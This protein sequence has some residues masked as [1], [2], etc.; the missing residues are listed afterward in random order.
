MKLIFKFAI[1][2]I[3]VSSVSVFNIGNRDNERLSPLTF[4]NIEAL[5]DESGDGS[6]FCI[7]VG[8]IDCYGFNAYYKIDHL[9]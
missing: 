3:V 1:A 4:D 9:K 8:S 2:F 6:Y 7:G 5:A